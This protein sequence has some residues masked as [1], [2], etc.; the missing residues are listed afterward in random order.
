[1]E[2][3]NTIAERATMLIGGNA[4]LG[5][6]MVHIFENL[7]RD[8]LK[9]IGYF[10]NPPN[11]WQQIK[12]EITSLL[13]DEANQEMIVGKLGDMLTSMPVKDAADVLGRIPDAEAERESWLTPS[14]QGQ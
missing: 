12:T 7:I 14:G 5:F 10:L 6:M 11:I 4:L 13:F 9:F 8:N 2:N 3:A 1:L